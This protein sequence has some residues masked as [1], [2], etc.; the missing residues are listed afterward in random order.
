MIEFLLVWFL[1]IIAILYA[2]NVAIFVL[3]TVKS[4]IGFSDQEPSA[5]FTRV[6]TFSKAM[7]TGHAV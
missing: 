4:R 1:I 3:L 7:F 2:V 6:A 5:Y